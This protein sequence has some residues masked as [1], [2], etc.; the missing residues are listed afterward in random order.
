MYITSKH[1][2]IF[3]MKKRESSSL[4][5]SSACKYRVTAKWFLSWN[6]RIFFLKIICY[7]KRRK[8]IFGR[9]QV[10]CFYRSFSKLVPWPEI[11]AIYLTNYVVYRLGGFPKLTHCRSPFSWEFPIFCSPTESSFLA[12]ITK[13]N[14]LN[15][16]WPNYE[17]CGKLLSQHAV[18][19]VSGQ[20]KNDNWADLCRICA[21]RDCQVW[22]WCKLLSSLLLGRSDF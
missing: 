12:M 16:Y 5:V 11:P 21:G 4:S 3:L 22:V 8:E 6:L 2:P 14:K 19:F 10:S 15:K 1:S 20:N 9:C 18:V 13:H 17:N 7:H